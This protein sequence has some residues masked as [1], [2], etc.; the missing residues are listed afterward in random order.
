MI[1]I[2]IGCPIFGN[3]LIYVK[4][5]GRMRAEGDDACASKRLLLR[6]VHPDKGA[7]LRDSGHG[8]WSSQAYGLLEKV[9]RLPAG[10][11]RSSVCRDRDSQSA[12]PYKEPEPTCAYK[13]CLAFAQPEHSN[14]SSSPSSSRMHDTLLLLSHELGHDPRRA[15]WHEKS[16]SALRF[17]MHIFVV[18][19]QAQMEAHGGNRFQDIA[20]SNS[21]LHRIPNLSALQA[22]M[23][24]R[25]PSIESKP[26]EA[27]RAC[28]GQ[29]RVWSLRL[30]GGWGI[31]NDKYYKLLGL[32]KGDCPSQVC[33]P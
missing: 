24:T 1:D 9:A 26:G 17:G 18:C 16:G 8:A 31:E 14:R 25:I 15:P 20:Q 32:N 22:C 2:C 3:V 10:P 13:T 27:S 12:S 29:G 6:V 19:I 21:G 7:A 11:M 28:A 23:R 30:R 33:W 4:L 5:V